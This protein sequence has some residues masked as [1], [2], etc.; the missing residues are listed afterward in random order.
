LVDQ[1][2]YAGQGGAEPADERADG[3]GLTTG[4]DRLAVDVDV[5]EGDQ[6]GS[7]GVALP[8]PGLLLAG[9]RDSR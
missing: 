2:G 9:F 3:V 8:R 4:L 1:H 5:T 7:P 6:V